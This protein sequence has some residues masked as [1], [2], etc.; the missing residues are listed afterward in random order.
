L[1]ASGY[2]AG[3]TY[4][5]VLSNEDTSPQNYAGRP[6]ENGDIIIAIKD[7]NVSTSGNTDWAIIEHNIDG[8]VFIGAANRG[9]AVGTTT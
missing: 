2:A 5:V 3:W 6:C 1:P 9:S 7:Y 8:A 4:R